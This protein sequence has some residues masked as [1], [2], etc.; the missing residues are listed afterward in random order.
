MDYNKTGAGSCNL[1]L[2][3][4]SSNSL[5]GATKIGLTTLLSNRNTSFNRK[6]YLN[7][8]TLDFLL[9]SPGPQPSNEFVEALFGPSTTTTVNPANNIFLIYTTTNDAVGT[10]AT[11]KQATVQKLKL[12]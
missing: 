4:N 10:V 6:L 1:R 11:S 8:T 5:S 2:Y 3:V 7:G 12:N 9:S